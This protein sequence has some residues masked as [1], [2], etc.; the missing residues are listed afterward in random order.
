LTLRLFALVGSLVIFSE[1]FA[2]LKVVGDLPTNFS[3]E[4]IAF[5]A[6]H[7]LIIITQINFMLYVAGYL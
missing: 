6:V 1:V 3:D 2:S 4:L 5:R 7:K